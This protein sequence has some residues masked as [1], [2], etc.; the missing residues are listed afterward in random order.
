MSSNAAVG[1][2]D[3]HAAHRAVRLSSGLSALPR[4]E[5][6]ARGSRASSSIILS[7]SLRRT[8][9]VSQAKSFQFSS[10]P[11]TGTNQVPRVLWP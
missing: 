7:K 3:L 6:R 11:V 8:C 9:Q 10:R 1:H 2:A 4:S 5:R